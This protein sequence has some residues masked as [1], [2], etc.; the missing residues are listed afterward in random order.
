[1]EIGNKENQN[2]VN[3][4]GNDV[5]TIIKERNGNVKLWW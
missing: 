2:N 1:M 4:A 5:V 3:A